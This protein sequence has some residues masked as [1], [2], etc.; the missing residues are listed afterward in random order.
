[1]ILRCPV[2]RWYQNLTVIFVPFTSIFVV[3]RSSI[4]S[5]F[6]IQEGRL[7]FLVVVSILFPFGGGGLLCVFI[8]YTKDRYMSSLLWKKAHVSL[9]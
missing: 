5:S 7:I 4:S 9:G 3:S 8:I 6:G 2:V 1:M